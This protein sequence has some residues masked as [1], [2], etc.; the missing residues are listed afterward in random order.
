MICLGGMQPGGG[1]PGCTPLSHSELVM[2]AIYQKL[3]ALVFALFFVIIGNWP[4]LAVASGGGEVFVELGQA[5][6]LIEAGATVLDAREPGDFERGRIPG[7]QNL[8]WQLFV[9]GEASGVLV[10]NDEHHQNLL[11]RAGVFAEKPVLIYGNWSAP[12]AWGEEGRLFWT[13]EYLGHG[14]VHILKGGIAAWEGAKRAVER[15]A[16]V[17]PPA[18]PGDF[19]VQRRASRRASTAEL[20]RSLN[21]SQR[22][23][24]LDSRER[25]EYEGQVKYGE[26]RAGHIPGAHHLEWRALFD[27]NGDLRSDDELRRLLA[28]FG[29]TKE[30]PIVAYCTGGVRSGF[31]YAALR[32]LGFA[33][34]QNYD[35]SMWDWTRD[36][37]LPL[38]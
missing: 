9:S 17:S 26:S 15:G 14:K 18:S 13:L 35:G 21:S 34:V 2:T 19:Q 28:D 20:A 12:G 29:A 24:I 23:V 10:D 38:Q 1:T 32:H 6:A 16:V 25:V 7:A 8:P 27:G 37:D 30:S 11:Q 33:K 22:P 4:S 5:V 3:S 36:P 31:V